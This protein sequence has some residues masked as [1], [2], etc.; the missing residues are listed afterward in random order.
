MACDATRSTDGFLHARCQFAAALCSMLWRPFY[1]EVH[2][3]LRSCMG[4]VF[5]L[6]CEEHY[7]HALIGTGGDDDVCS[8]PHRSLQEEDPLDSQAPDISLRAP[9]HLGRS[10]SANVHV[11]GEEHAGS[12]VVHIRSGD[13]F[14]P[15]KEGWHGMIWYGQVRRSMWEH[16]VVASRWILKGLYGRLRLQWNDRALVIRI[17]F[18]RCPMART[19]ELITSQVASEQRCREHSASCE[20]EMTYSSSLQ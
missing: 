19:I 2:D 10:D 11:N 15:E 7:L 16:L 1:P 6:G 17:S 3:D 5:L 9:G 18:S 4:S 14:K 20:S 8:Q 13:I 12:L